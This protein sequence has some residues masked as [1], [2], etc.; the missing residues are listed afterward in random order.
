MVD[1][2]VPSPLC[3]SSLSVYPMEYVVLVFLSV[4]EITGSLTVIHAVPI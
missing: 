1:S 3:G 2:N 4:V